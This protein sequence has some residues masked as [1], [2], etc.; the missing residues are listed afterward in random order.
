MANPWPI[1]EQFQWIAQSEQ[2][3]AQA[4]QALH[5]ERQRTEQLLAQLRAAGIKPEAERDAPRSP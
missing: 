2:R 4:E 5:Q 1:Y 3:A